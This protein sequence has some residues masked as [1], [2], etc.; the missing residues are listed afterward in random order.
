MANSALEESEDD[1]NPEN[2]FDFWLGEWDAR[3]SEDGSA[4]NT[5]TRI[6][7]GKIV[8]EDFVAP[9]LHGMSFSSYDPE[10]KLWCQT[11]VDNN[12]TYLDFTGTFE[13]GKIILSR[14]AVVRG[15]KCKQRMVWYDIEEQQFKWNWER[16]NDGGQTWRTLWHI[17]YTRK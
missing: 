7:D 17:D 3:W 9:D 11:W 16:S 5:V 12:G 14:D 8:Q 1:M 6:L 15:E 4:T 2:Q 10:R 13:D